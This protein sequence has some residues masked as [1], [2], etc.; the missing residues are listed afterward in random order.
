MISLWQAGGCNICVE[1]QSRRQLQ[2]DEV[3]VIAL[4]RHVSV[5]NTIGN[6]NGLSAVVIPVNNSGS[7][8][9]STHTLIQC[10]TM[11]SRHDS[12]RI[13]NSSAAE[14]TSAGLALSDRN[15]P[16]NG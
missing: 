15:L 11:S 8:V 5:P 14:V 12:C 13:Q 4:V 1:A 3:I 16:W 2:N 9:E 10:E 7:N 6:F